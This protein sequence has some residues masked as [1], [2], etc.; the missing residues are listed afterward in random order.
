MK[1]PFVGR[2]NSS[3]LQH[4]IHTL[5]PLF[6]HISEIKK[7]TGAH[8]DLLKFVS[9]SC[10]KYS[11]ILL[12]NHFH[13]LHQESFPSSFISFIQYIPQFLF[14]LPST[15]TLPSSVHDIARSLR[16]L[17]VIT[18]INGDH[19]SG[20]CIGANNAITKTTNNR[21]S[22]N[23]SMIKKGFKHILRHLKAEKL[24]ITHTHTLGLF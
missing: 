14:L 22:K 4:Y 1:S 17:I 21:E 23:I 12:R 11:N 10:L 6:T 9:A 8:S 5:Q 18:A 2:Q 20:I 16:Q 15:A 7:W 3:S 19:H 13:I 24:H